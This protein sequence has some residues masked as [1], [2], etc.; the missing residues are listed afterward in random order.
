MMEVMCFLKIRP[1]ELRGLVKR[2][3]RKREIVRNECT[4]TGAKGED[5][6]KW[7]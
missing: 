1:S 3:M 5:V 7:M 2:E 4:N 6:D